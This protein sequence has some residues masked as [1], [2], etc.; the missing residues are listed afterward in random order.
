MASRIN[1][2][3]IL[4]LIIITGVLFGLVGAVWYINI[5]TNVDRLVRQ[6]DEFAQQGD[7]RKAARLYERA[8]AK[9][10]GSAAY[11]QKM[12]DAVLAIRPDTADEARTRYQEFIS[13]LK[14]GATHHPHEAARHQ[15]LLEEMFST[16]RRSS[17]PAY[18]QAIVEAADDMLELPRTDPARI[19]A[20]FY[21][22]AAQMA[23][24]MQNRLTEDQVKDGWRA[25]A[26]RLEGDDEDPEEPGF[27]EEVPDSDMGWATLIDGLLAQATR[28]HDEGRA[29]KADEKL[30]EVDE[31]LA[32]A[33]AN[34]EDGPEV[35]L[36]SLNTVHFKRRIGLPDPDHD[37]IRATVD[38]M[39]RLVRERQDP[40]LNT[41]A[42]TVL[43]R[44][45]WVE[46]L[47][48]PIGF[49]EAYIAEHPD[50]HDQ[51]LSK[52]RLQYYARDFDGAET[53]CD[54][55]IEA[56]ILPV[57]YLSQFQDELRRGAAALKVDIAMRRWETADQADRPELLPKIDVAV[58][59]LSTRTAD[60]ESDLMLIRARAKAAYAREDYR[61]A[62]ALFNRLIA[63]LGAPDF[64]T[65]LYS[66]VALEQQGQP[67]AALDRYLAAY[68]MSPTNV[69]LGVRLLR[70]QLELKQY[71][72]AIALADRIIELDPENDMAP[73]IRAESLR[74]L[75]AADE[76]IGD[77]VQVTLQR[78]QDAIERGELDEARGILQGA[79]R[80]W[81]DDL[82]ILN[83]LI[84]VSMAT[85]RTEDAK[86][87]CE[88]A[89]ELSPGNLTFEQLRARIEND[90]PIEVLRAYA[91]ETKT[92]ELGAAVE[93]LLAMRQLA[94]RRDAEAERLEKGGRAEEAEEARAVA[95]RARAEEKVQAELVERLD[96]ND[97]RFIDYKFVNAVV[98]ED[99]DAA[100]ALVD[101]A[102]E[103][104]ADQA[105][106]ALFR[107]RYE[108]ARGNTEAAVRAFRTGA[109][110]L[111]F[112]DNAWRLLASAYT[113]AGN[114]DE[115]L[116]ALERAYSNN[117]TH[118]ET[119]MA[120][121]A[122]LVRTGNKT[123]ALEVFRNG[124]RQAPNLVPMR[125]QWLNLELDVGDASIAM[126]RRSALYEGDPED[127]INAAALAILIGTLEP[128]RELILDGR[129]QPEHTAE[130][131]NRMSTSAR[132]ALIDETQRRWR[133]EAVRIVEK[134]LPP[135]ER[136]LSW[137][138]LRARVH[139]GSGNIDAGGQ[140][141]RDFADR[142][143]AVQDKVDALLALGIFYS[144]ARRGDQAAAALLEASRLETGSNRAKLALGELY[145]SEQRYE[146]ALP[147]FEAI[148]GDERVR[149]IELHHAECLLMIGR[150]DEARR[151]L[152][153]LERT[154]GTNATSTMLRA[155]L[156]A[157]EADELWKEG[158]QEEAERRFEEHNEM[159]VLAGDLSPTDPMP[160]VLRAR[161]YYNAYE[162]TLER[163]YLD[164]ALSAL[165][166]ADQVSEGFFRTS[167]TRVAVLQA[168]GARTA[169]QA[170]L[171]R[172]LERSP[173]Q[174]QA[175]QVLVQMLLEDRRI[176]RAIAVAE[177]A[178]R[179]DPYDIAWRERLGNILMS[180]KNDAVAAAQQFEAAV[181]AS[182][183]PHLLAKAAESYLTARP[184]LNREAV[185][186]IG[187]YPEML[188]K[189][190]IVRAVYARA[191]A[192]QGDRAGALE[193]MRLA[194][195]Q[196]REIINAGN[197]RPASIN[198]W[199]SVLRNIYAPEEA[200]DA[201]EFARGLSDTDPDAYEL[202]ALATLW[203]IQGAAGYGRSIELLREGLK[204]C[205][206]N[207]PQLY[208]RLNSDLA[209]ML[210]FTDE[211]DLAL[212]AF[213]GVLEHDPDNVEVLNNTAYLLDEV[214]RTEEAL[215]Y[216]QRARALSVPPQW[217]V[218]DTLGVI[219]VHMGQC[220]Q[221]QSTLRQAAEIDRNPI[222]LLHLA[223]AL[224]CLSEFDTA[225][226]FLENAAQLKPD[227][228]TLKQIQELSDD[229]R[230]KARGG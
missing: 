216:A 162:R 29:T 25:L 226:R 159:L 223:M 45:A 174:D 199:Y 193:E 15:R 222:V 28:L 66:A 81:P 204:I 212:E 57:S 195:Y 118:V 153:D 52:A 209:V 127:E 169:A 74:Q 17:S 176:A 192:Q 214:G 148:T 24:W 179:L 211:H 205:P 67:G 185:D 225:L 183:Q 1:T 50:A 175:R 34:V 100:A 111:S 120:Y 59:E 124:R 218:L 38:E 98:E 146:E 170:E 228:E 108:L 164:D 202:L 86:K 97:V 32:T 10:P 154:S 165:A 44:L 87:F 196:Q 68:E 132:D 151:A 157:H 210:L 161:S 115:A 171:E 99:W 122:M 64:E 22:G 103:Y 167:L 16:F 82:R 62:A 208:T 200:R 83:G 143:E 177:D 58:T 109:D 9:D 90:D 85:G 54:E 49:V 186:L 121:G 229:I 106:G 156:L 94:I 12:E 168:Q 114:L 11:L 180:E 73:M 125:E 69:E 158:R 84:R 89:L 152:D 188:K 181:Q 116:N 55:I 206:D 133:A 78:G 47:P 3:F 184:P 40:W 14:H 173:E 93:L 39:M 190:P 36:A 60:P 172:L 123:R 27:L 134:L 126:A 147:I 77:P 230:T 63:E 197:A 88:R 166:R 2:K 72:H 79:Y 182:P 43:A 31:A 71:E 145:F 42:A 56:E 155:S 194:Y 191:L 51:R 128:R 131:W 23:S 92:T 104:D 207:A 119:I 144:E 130:R 70:T 215:P 46:D 201:E 112:S 139:Q 37:E 142:Q 91:T 21:S 102:E 135:E 198:G 4:I 96:P 129:G 163:V 113:T 18:S 48:D 227:P 141:L 26:G 110:R 117:P 224:D 33:R 149:R 187:R 95:T 8:I 220:R 221:A 75:G 107:G 217:S 219:Q 53:A 76:I 5:K 136:D 178:I 35:L 13:I 160:H 203:R 105:G 150:L 80:K 19:Q 7:Y 213:L 20:Q 65:L 30:A 101:D 61:Q 138:V 189:H 41:Q 6:G 140:E 137:H